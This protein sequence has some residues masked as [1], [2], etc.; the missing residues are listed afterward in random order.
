MKILIIALARTGSS[1]LLFKLASENNLK[2]IFEPFRGDI[3]NEYFDGTTRWIYNE[4]EDNI[5]V[6]TIVHH[7]KD[8]ISLAKKFDKVI[9]LSRKNIKECAESSI[10]FFKNKENGYKSWWPYY[11]DNIREEELNS[12]IEIV[13]EHHHQLEVISRELNIPITYY[14]DIYDINSSDRLRK[15][16]KKEILKNRLI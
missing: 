3:E 16:N 11:Y 7:H 2:P 4:N 14:E 1:N 9:L 12:V 15:F 6:K 8:N 13:K 10:Y 5:V